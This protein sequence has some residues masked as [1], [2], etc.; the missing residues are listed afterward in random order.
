MCVSSAHISK[1]DIALV[2]AIENI[3]EAQ[4]PF[5]IAY[6]QISHLQAL[7]IAQ[8]RALSIAYANL[9]QY[10]PPL[11]SE[12]EDFAAYANTRLENEERLLRGT[13]ADLAML[14]RIPV[15][16]AFERE[17]KRPTARDRTSLN[18][19]EDGKPAKRTLA[20]LLSV[21]KL[22]LVKKDVLGVHGM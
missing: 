17:K 7:F 18:E 19:G 11:A 20:D 22:Q 6:D 5:V 8:A 3:N 10:I 15:H 13:D 14:S 1:A 9:S 4:Q 12:Y 21:R 16:E 2:S